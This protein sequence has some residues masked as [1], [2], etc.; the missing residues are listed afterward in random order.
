MR[1]GL[2]QW[3][4]RQW[5]RAG[6]MDVEGFLTYAKDLG[7]EGVE[8]LDY[9]WKD[10]EE[11]QRTPELL[12]RMGL[13][14][15]SYSL[16]NDFADD[17]AQ[18]RREQLDYMR[19]GIDDV[20]MLGAKTSRVFGGNPKEGMSYEKAR[21]YIVE[22]IKASAEYAASKGVVLALEN[23]GRLCGQAD[24]VLDLI[25]AVGSDHFRSNPDLANFTGV[26]D[27]PVEATRKLAKYTVH[28]HA[29][30][31]LVVPPEQVAEG[32]RRRSDGTALRGCALGEGSVDLAACLDVLREAGFTGFLSVEYEGR[33]D[34]KT[35]VPKS[36][37]YVRKLLGR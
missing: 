36:V 24:Q 7:C 25:A 30:D 35:G 13:V 31:I 4:V 17:D 11:K 22:G 28:V 8:L 5:F 6:E 29:K 32:E 18:K 14:H 16:S 27:D 3:S 34:P 1:L 2:S 20:V 19:A 21:N 37:E 26:M 15:S 9:F 23:H 33:E 10:E 12:E